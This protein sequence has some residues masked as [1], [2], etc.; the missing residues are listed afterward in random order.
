M[1]YLDVPFAV[2]DEAKRLGAKW[3]G[4]L[5][6]W[7]VPHGVDIHLFSNWWPKTLKQETL[8]LGQL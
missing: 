8:G 3:D 7:Y 5:R 2:K 1:L 4:A 6:K